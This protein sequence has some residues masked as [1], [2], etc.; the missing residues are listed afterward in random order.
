MIET[1]VVKELISLKHYGKPL[2]TKTIFWKFIIPW[3]KK[4]T[5]P[6]AG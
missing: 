6:V 3:P 1:S 2:A 4:Y 5:L